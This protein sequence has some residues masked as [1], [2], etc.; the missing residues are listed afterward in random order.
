MER[1]FYEALAADV[2]KKFHPDRQRPRDEVAPAKEENAQEK[3]SSF[4][5][6]FFQ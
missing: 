3:S 1:P 2:F 5:F 4:I 6:Y